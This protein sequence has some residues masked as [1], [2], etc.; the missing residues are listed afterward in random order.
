[1]GIKREVW[2]IIMI[3]I[4]IKGNLSKHRVN[5]NKTSLRVLHLLS[6]PLHQ[7]AQDIDQPP[8]AYTG[9]TLC[10]QLMY[11]SSS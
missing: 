8:V 2:L 11:Y 5:A 10:L 9:R 3:M 7:P 1:M 6:S 4:I